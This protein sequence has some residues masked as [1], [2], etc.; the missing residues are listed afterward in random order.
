M[1]KVLRCII[2][3]TILVILLI[4]LSKIFVPKNN[5]AEAG[6]DKNKALAY[7]ILAEP[8]GTIDV[9]VT[10]DSES[11]SSYI[12]MEVW[13]DYG[14]SSY[15]CGTPAQPLPLTFSL[16]KDTF[17]KQDLKLVVLEANTIYL[18]KSIAEPIIQFT[19][20]TMPIVQYHDRWKTITK[21]DLF[22]DIKYTAIQESKG[23]YYSNDVKPTK[24]NN[25]MKKTE[26]IQSISKVNKL[27]VKMIKKYCEK[28]GAQFMIYSSPSIKNWSYEKHNG[29]EELAKE[30][31][32]EYVDLNLL[33]D[34]IKIDWT[35]D[36]RDNGDHL[37]YIGAVKITKF[38]GKYFKEHYNLEDHKNDE[39]YK[40][41]NEISEKK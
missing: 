8:E 26:D 18:K 40:F 4:F 23:Y 39:K 33:Q 28:N 19:R 10:G 38:L 21:K 5:T 37:N 6:F 3:L 34:E 24:N 30:L 32:V 31:D 9:L 16:I 27:F 2:F 7:G 25:Y 14:I 41:W 36:S 20:N 17:K 12:P 1:K 15:V 29:I 35:K 11:Y 13:N 22:N